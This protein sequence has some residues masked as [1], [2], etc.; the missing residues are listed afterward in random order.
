MKSRNALVLG[1][2]LVCPVPAGSAVAQLSAACN[3]SCGKTATL[4]RDTRASEAPRPQ[5]ERPGIAVFPLDFGGSLDTKADGLERLSIGLQQ[6][7]LDQFVQ[8]PAVRVVER[9]RLKEIM[10]EQQ[11]SQAGR[12][13]PQT[14]ARIGKLVGARYMVLGFFSEMPDLQIGARVVDTET[15]QILSSKLVS[16][17]RDKMMSLVIDLGRQIEGG[18]RGLPALPAA[19][20]EARQ[21]QEKVPAD[22]LFLYSQALAAS[23]NGLKDTAADLYQRIIREFPT[24]TPAK[25]KLRQLRGG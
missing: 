5:Q 4:S 23:D 25:E 24:F 11:L 20:R 9:L 16:G 17:K 12:V 18:L 2:A 1:L 6:V 19:V 7:L 13:D 14:A 15:G 21:E 8:N 3:E 10:D 22:A